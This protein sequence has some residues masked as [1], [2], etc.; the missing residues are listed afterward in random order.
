MPTTSLALLER[1]KVLL[2]MILQVTGMSIEPTI[3][4]TGWVGV[5]LHTIA[6][7]KG[8]VLFFPCILLEQCDR[9]ELFASIRI[10][11]Y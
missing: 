3:G 4:R 2:G 1:A 10:E 9:P 7:C 11:Q 8:L 6:F 5:T